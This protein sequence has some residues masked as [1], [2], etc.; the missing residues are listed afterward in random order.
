MQWRPPVIVC[1]LGGI[2][3]TTN[4]GTTWKPVFDS[5]G[6]YSIGCLAQDPN[7]PHVIWAGSGENN[8]QRSVS[9]GDGVYR[10]KN[11]GKSW[12]NMGLK[13]SEHIGKILIDPRDSNTVFVA[14]QEDKADP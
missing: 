1:R 4:A 2:W 12:E 10:S 5:Y 11:G 14:A 13:E 6:S 3:E 7:N 8:S 9:F